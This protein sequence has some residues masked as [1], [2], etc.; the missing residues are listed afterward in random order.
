M[1]RE[2]FC[3]NSRKWIRFLALYSPPSTCPYET[4]NF[5]Q[6][7]NCGYMQLRKPTK[8]LLNKIKTLN[9]FL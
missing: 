6:C 2:E 1:K 7:Q 5:M 9:R 4:E 8:Y 3:G